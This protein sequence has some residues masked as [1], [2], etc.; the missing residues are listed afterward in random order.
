MIYLAGPY[1]H[2]DHHVRCYRFRALTTFA[3]ELLN[4]GV[5]VYS[6][7]THSHPMTEF[8]ALPHT[9]DFW[10]KV[11]REYI[12]K[13]NLLL[14]LKLD[15]WEQSIG[16]QAEIEIAGKLGILVGYVDPKSID[17][18]IADL[19]RNIESSPKVETS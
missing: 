12:E 19:H 6:P 3:A 14:V 15:G 13:C 9:W 8:V 5:N 2:H 10:Q 16:V 4:A 18:F 11:D 7:I 17:D 1:S